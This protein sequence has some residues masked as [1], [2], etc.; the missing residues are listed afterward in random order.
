MGLWSTPRPGRFTHGKER[1]TYCIGGWV[2]PR[3]SLDACEKILLPPVF[4]P[5]K[6]GVAFTRPLFA[7]LKI[8]RTVPVPNFIPDGRKIS[9]V[10]QTITPPKYGFFTVLIFMKLANRSTALLGDAEHR[11]S[12]KSVYQYARN[13]QQFVYNFK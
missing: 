12:P 5:P 6:W 3:A 4:D 8:K 11:I 9:V 10:Q 2:G 7:K 13:G 1:G